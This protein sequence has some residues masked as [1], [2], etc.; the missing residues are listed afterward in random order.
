MNNKFHIIFITT[1]FGGNEIAACKFIETL[2]LSGANIK[3]S[4]Q[5]SNA[6]LL[7]YLNEKKLICVTGLN[8]I[9]DCKCILISSSV[10]S[11]IK[12]AYTKKIKNA[13]IYAPFIGTEWEDNRIIIL[14]KKILIKFFTSSVFFGKYKIL[15]PYKRMTKEL[16]TNE[17]N[18]LIIPNVVNHGSYKTIEEIQEKNTI[19][20]Y[21]I[22]RIEFNQKQQHLLLEAFKKIINDFNGNINLHF[23]GDGP[24]ETRLKHS[25]ES[26][27]KITISPWMPLPISVMDNS[28]VV[29]PSSFEGLPLVGLEAISSN[30]PVIA[31]EKSGMSDFIPEEC[32]FNPKEH[33]SLTLSINYALRNKKSILNDGN[34]LISTEHSDTALKIA[35]NKLRNF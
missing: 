20:L 17:E 32:I 21:C 27:E 11:G 24:D 25:I 31:T 19:N 13:Y 1:G 26:E 12:F 5:K 34:K 7:D 4:I 18:G 9:K 22:G 6:R 10:T 3:I 14:A 30:I 23:I 29:L 16:R 33:K 2:M 35:C 28:V 15:A 8:N